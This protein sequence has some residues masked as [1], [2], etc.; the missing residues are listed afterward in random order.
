[1]KSIYLADTQAIIKFLE[2]KKVIS[3]SIDH[4]FTK[5]DNNE[6]LIFL[7]VITLMEI[8]YLEEKNR[9]KITIDD[10]DYL[11]K[12][13]PNLIV[14]DLDV[15]IIKTAKEIKDIP[16]L[17]DRLI[18]ATARYLKIP[19]LTNDPIIQDSKFVECIR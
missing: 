17:H 5:F 19:I 11:Q 8:F 2:G 14:I 12:L 4:I 3:S 10:I 18:A 13:N 9:I 1:M 16:E 6:I 7:S 15:E